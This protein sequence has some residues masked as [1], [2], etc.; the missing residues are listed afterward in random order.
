MK[1][2]KFI[3][4]F[5]LIGLLLVFSCTKEDKLNDVVVNVKLIDENYYAYDDHS[6]VKVIL[7]RGQEEFQEITDSNGD[8]IFSNFPYGIFNVKLEKEGFVSQYITPE[9]TNHEN[10]SSNVHSYQMVEIPD[11]KISIDSINVSPD[12]NYNWRLIAFGKLYN[13]Q[14]TPQISYTGIANFGD[15]ENVSKDDYILYHYCEIIKYYIDGD[16]CQIW[17]TRWRF[18]DL[19]PPGY[20]T[21]YIRFYPTPIYPEWIKIREDALGEPSDV[22]EWIV[23]DYK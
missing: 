7:S 5:A 23:P 9:L 16:N 3:K 19:I 4:H 8:C 10:D 6:G 1:V 2:F 20:D 18:D 13:T 17:I 22:Y 21:L 14:G 11:I 12:W 15:T